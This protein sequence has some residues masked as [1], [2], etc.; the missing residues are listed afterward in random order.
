MNIKIVQSTSPVVLVGGGSFRDKDLARAISMA[1]TVVAADGG[2]AAVLAAGRMPDAVIGDM[3]SLPREVQAQLAPGVL[4]QV[5]EQDSTDFD[6]C[7]RHIEAPL[8]LGH[9]FLGKRV[10]H[11]LAA[12]NVLARR[13]DR[14]CILVGKHDVICHCPP[15]ITLDL[16]VGDRLSLFPMRPVTGRSEGL[17]W[18]LEGI[19]FAP[20]GTTGTS[21]EVSGPV[22]LEMDGP[23]MLLILPAAQHDALVAALGRA[24]RWPAPA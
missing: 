21:N 14:P 13:P 18:P 6:K 22:T 4:R 15:R 12:M 1:E 17:R 19:G 7:L 5:A 2:A 10:D 24:V 11:Q 16:P 20:G 8:V 23:G 3:D 9:G